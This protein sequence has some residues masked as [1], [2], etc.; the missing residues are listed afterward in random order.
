MTQAQKDRMTAA[1]NSLIK[2]WPSRLILTLITT[3]CGFVYV[4]GNDMVDKRI[5]AVMKPSIDSL[6]KQQDSTAA[7]VD[8]VDGKLNALID[9]MREAFPQFKQKALERAQDNKDSKDVQDA[10]TGGK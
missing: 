10:L 6:A 2:D 4:K 1:K 9:V 3:F 8:G 7:K 5:Q